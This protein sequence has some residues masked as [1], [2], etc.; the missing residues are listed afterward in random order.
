MCESPA[1]LSHL[2]PI[3]PAM[4]GR[5]SMPS[6][7]S[8]GRLKRYIK[9]NVPLHKLTCSSSVKSSRSRSSLLLVSVKSLSAYVPLMRRPKW[10]L[11]QKPITALTNG[12][13]LNFSSLSAPNDSLSVSASFE[14]QEKPPPTPTSHVHL[15]A[16]AG[17]AA[18]GRIN[19]PSKTAL[20]TSLI[21]PL[22]FRYR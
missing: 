2:I 4:Y 3:P 11:G 10:L 18:N 6:N 8:S 22:F 20:F 16:D 15:C 1:G 12:L 13:E 14:S 5:I 7:S 17:A 9:S 19:A 21:N